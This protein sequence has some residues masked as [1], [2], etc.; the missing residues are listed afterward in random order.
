MSSHFKRATFGSLLAPLFAFAPAIVCAQTASAPKP[1]NPTTLSQQDLTNEIR[2]LR[3]RLD[4]LEA[5]E[6]KRILDEQQRQTKQAVIDDADKHSSFLD[7]H[8]LEVTYD[9]ERGFRLATRDNN[10]V[11]HPWAQFQ[12]RNVTT[13]RQDAPPA[14]SD[15]TQ[16]GFEVRRLRFALEGNAFTPDLTYQ[17]QVDQDRHNGTPTVLYAWGQYQIPDS[18]FAIRAGQLAEPLDHEQL[19]PSRD[20]SAIDRTLVDDIFANGEA[21][22]QGVYGSYTKTDMRAFAGF[23]DGLRSSNTNF[24][25]PPTNSTDWGTV[26]RFEYKFFGNWIDY[27]HLSSYG[28][29]EQLLVLGAGLDYTEANR[30]SALTHVVDAHAAWPNGLLLY[31]AYLGRYVRNNSFAGAPI[32][33]TYDA[34]WRT[35][36]SYLVCKNWEPYIQYEYIHFDPSQFA[37]GTDVNVHVIRVGTSYYIYGHRLKLQVDGSYLPNGSPVSDDAIGILLNNGH[38][39]FILR[40]QMQLFL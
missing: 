18:P 24:Q 38:N 13:H 1:A 27:R 16:N 3:A 35:Q 28:T 11:F 36:I 6:Q 10:F 5:Q 33:D 37:P 34:T 7:P 21:I 25:D 20:L 17:F 22:V 9:Q 2:A 14:G 32:G 40:A 26:A 30:A 23:S 19:S 31:A 4:Q 8:G 15:D 29:K 39:E 12:F